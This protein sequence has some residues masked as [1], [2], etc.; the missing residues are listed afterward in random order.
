MFSWEIYL[1]SFWVMLGFGGLGWLYSLAKKNVTVVDSMWS[2]FFLLGAISSATTIESFPSNRSILIFV[3]VSLWSLRLSIFLTK[4]NIGHLEDLR[5]QKIRANNQPFWIKSLYII[6]ALQATLAWFISLPIHGAMLSTKPLG[7]LDLFGVILWVFGFLWESIGD[8]QLAQFKANPSN[9]GKVMDLGLWRYSRHP[10]YFGEC[11]LWWGYFLISVSAG[12][13]W[14]F[15]APILMTILL[16]KVSGVS[17][18][19][20]TIVERR[21]EYADYIKRTNAFIPSLAKRKT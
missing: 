15:P 5:Y 12:A 11:T 21:P 18:L 13:W 17:L 10:N 4:R 1:N 20:S 8:R 3:L 19:E 6:F 14:S 2:I 9:K 7:I 16:L